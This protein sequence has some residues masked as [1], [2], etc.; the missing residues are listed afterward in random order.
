MRA[1]EPGGPETIVL[2]LVRKLRAGRR[3]HFNEECCSRSGDLG[4]RLAIAHTHFR[5]LS[6]QQNMEKSY[7]KEGPP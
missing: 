4:G 6:S 3:A 5:A 2:H 7:I 1:P